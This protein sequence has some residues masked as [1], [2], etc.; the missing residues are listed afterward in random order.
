MLVLTR[1]KTEK[2]VLHD[3]T[4]RKVVITILDN[5]SGQTRIGIEAPNDVQVDREEIYNRKQQEANNS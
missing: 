2:L 1:R 3:D 4:G 5:R